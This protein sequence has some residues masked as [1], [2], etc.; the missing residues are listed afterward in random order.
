MCRPLT[1]GYALWVNCLEGQK[2]K[3]AKRK[4]QLYGQSA[5]SNQN[6]WK[7]DIRYRRSLIHFLL[8]IPKHN[9]K[10]FPLS[11]WPVPLSIYVHTKQ[12]KW[13]SISDSVEQLSK[14]E[15]SRG[16]CAVGSRERK[17]QSH[18]PSLKYTSY[19]NDYVKYLNGQELSRS[20][21]PLAT[22]LFMYFN[23][24]L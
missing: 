15:M 10:S 1:L 8:L 20:I 6:I 21:S 19:C 12:K 17:E 23:E 18:I 4:R 7:T 3:P 2:R 5:G 24:D 14:T 11:R 13:V 9:N 16:L 22:P